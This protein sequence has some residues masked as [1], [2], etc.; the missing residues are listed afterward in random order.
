MKKTLLLMLALVTM[1]GLRA[2]TKDLTFAAEG[3]T[4][5]TWDSS[6]RIFTWGNKPGR[7]SW[8]SDDWTFVAV[9]N[10]SG[11]LS[12]YTK[13]VFKL[14]NFT[15]SEEEKLTL[16]FKE[17][18]GNTQSMDYVTKVEL[19]PDA[20]GVVEINLTKFDWK[21]MN[22]SEETIDNTKIFD[23]T[24]YGGARTDADQ[25]G[26]VK[27]TEAYISDD[28]ILEDEVIDFDGSFYHSWSEVSASATDNGAVEGSHIKLGEEV[29]LGGTIWGDF[30]GSVPHLNYANLS[31]YSE[32]IITGTPNAVLRLMCN[33]LVDE[34][35]IYEIKPTIPTDGVLT[36]SI[37]DLKYLNGGT[38]CDFVCLQSIKEMVADW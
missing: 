18:K 5:S 6:T 32:M 28:P 17:N 2:E 7:E 38:A 4:N 8:M 12:S 30:T 15:N 9:S 3:Y 37:S 26:S 24:L 34:G 19:V 31:E 20:N 22:N 36:I 11:D 21:N 13:L 27:L 23:V 14:E 29:A 16:Y 33:R 25:S 10:L 1:G 35:P